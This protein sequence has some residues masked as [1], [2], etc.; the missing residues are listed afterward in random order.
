MKAALV[1]NG[2]EGEFAVK[3]NFIICADGGYNLLKDRKPNIIIGDMDSITGL[4]YGIEVVKHPPE[5]NLTDGELAIDWA[6]KN[7]YTD[8][9][10]YG[11]LGGRIDHILCNLSLLAFA[12]QRGAAAKIKSDRVNIYYYKEGIFN[13]KAKTSDLISLLPYGGGVLFSYSKG[14]KYPLDNLS[15]S[16][17]QT[18]LGLSN[19]AID[20]SV[21]VGIQKGAVFV[22]HHK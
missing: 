17:F 21:E 19:V 6:V 8:L 9:V 22:V 1:L 7:G 20:E 10:I 5:K 18:G 11:A 13:L 2:K 4:P 14:L 12:N 3:E 15:L 16:P